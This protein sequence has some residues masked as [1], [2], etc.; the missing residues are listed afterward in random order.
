[1]W[2]EGSLLMVSPRGDASR[3]LRR[4][5]GEVDTMDLVIG[6]VL[7]VVLPC[8]FYFGAGLLGL[9]TGASK[10]NFR[11]KVEVPPP[12]PDAEEVQL[13]WKV[14][15][16]LYTINAKDFMSMLSV[17]E[18]QELQQRFMGWALRCLENAKGQLQELESLIRSDVTATQKFSGKLMEA[19]TLGRQIKQDLA[20]VRQRDV[21]GVYSRP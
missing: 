19:A 1:M 8:F 3:L 7:L 18:D 21:L 12:A 5:R 17:S 2:S 14:A 10:M 9:G 16:D 11:D 15:R 6:L 13:R 20:R 4:Q